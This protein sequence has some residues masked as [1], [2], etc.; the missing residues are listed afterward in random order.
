MSDSNVGRRG[1][2]GAGATAAA[3]GATL[4][5]TGRAAAAPGPAD[6]SRPEHGHDGPG[7]VDGTTTPGLP[8]SDPGSP[9]DATDPGEHTQELST[10]FAT[11]F[12]EPAGTVA[13]PGSDG[14][15]WPTCWGDDD[16]VYAA[17]GDGRG[18]SDEPFKDVVV[19]RIA[20]TPETGLTGEKL[21]ESEQVA[22]VWADPT[23]YNRKP[24][25]MVC[26]GGVLYLAVQDL[27][28]GELAFDDV[29]NASI[30]RSDDHGKTWQK[31]D[32]AMFTDYR[33]TTV[34][35]LDFG[36]NSAHAVPALG[37]HDGAYVY[38][39]GMDW[40]WR[41]S[42]ANIVPDPVDLYLGRVPADSVQDR[43]KWEFFTGT[44]GRT[45]T[46]SARIEDKVP[47][48][49]DPLRR[50]LDPR[51]GQGGN[52]TVVSQGGV[53]YSP[54][55]KRYIYSSWSDPSFELYESPTPWGP[56]KRFKYHN[57][58]LVTWYQMGDKVNTPKNGGY[59]TTIPSKF[60]SKDGRTMW[61]QSNWWTAPY[62]KPED[63]Y[64]FNL[65]KVLVTP[66]SD[67]KSRN[68]PNRTDNLARSGADVT[69]IE[70]SDHFAHSQ[71]YNDGDKTKVED[72]FDGTNKNVDFWGYT[73]SK[74]YRMSRV[75]YTTGTMFPDGGWFSPYAGGLRV[76]V[77]QGF[78]WVDVDH[79]SVTPGYPYDNTAGPTKTY[80][81]RFRS[82]WGDGV[83]IVGQPGGGAHFTSIA[84][85]EVYYDG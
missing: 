21:A 6:Y 83:R 17:N 4:A 30:S 3:A 67:T 22:N 81:M 73:F 47:V 2:L 70:I 64:N 38:A 41:L 58:G 63:N 53:L 54:A 69:P 80:S 68:K 7:V 76:Q 71:Y 66:Y 37:R 57:S 75:E 28:Y 8:W 61:M 24:T 49:H 84:E 51:P 82:T 45:P 56:W 42:S 52:L 85:L 65:R 77:R 59:G 39:Y 12:I 32:K 62:P 1:F 55:F 9:S 36:K 79:L 15:L 11:T 34:F 74:A 23:K 44:R 46:W 60:V 31:T 72:S 5:V 48:L 14:D 26:T 25:G 43:A 10:F 50:Y 20:G 13:A 29:P 27:K 78:R 33:F 19:S 35:F 18:F 40:N 16:Y